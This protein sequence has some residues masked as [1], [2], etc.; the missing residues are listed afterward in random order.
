MND[1]HSQTPV[2]IRNSEKL[3]RELDRVGV[4]L[5]TA[6]VDFG[7]TVSERNT[8][9]TILGPELLHQPRRFWQGTPRQALKLLQQL[10]DNAGT[11]PF[12]ALF[13]PSGHRVSSLS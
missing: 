9:I 1:E 10:P 6:G 13:D 3:A 7:V 5:R 11:K 4:S 12:W 2:W 8:Q